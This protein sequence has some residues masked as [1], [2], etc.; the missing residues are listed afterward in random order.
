M[1]IGTRAISLPRE[2]A[3]EIEPPCQVSSSN[4]SLAIWVA[5][6]SA[7]RGVAYTHSPPRA[8]S[9]RRPKF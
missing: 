3:T 8:R 4:N 5:C 6:A 7:A 9:S 1:P 2:S